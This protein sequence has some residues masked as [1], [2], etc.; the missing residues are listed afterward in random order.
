LRILLVG[1]YPPIEGGVSGAV[2][3]AAQDLATA[4]HHVDVV[5]NSNEVEFGFREFFWGADESL[6]Q[7]KTAAGSVSVLETRPLAPHS[8]VPWTNPHVSKVVGR[9]LAATRVHE[10]DAIV[11]VYLEPYGVAAALVSTV[12]EKP[13]ILRHA[14]SDIGRLSEH[15]DLQEIYR[16]ALSRARIVLTGVRT[17]PAYERLLELGASLNQVR[18]LG[19]CA[20]PA[21]FSESNEVL[22]VMELADAFNASSWPS[23]L[24]PRHLNEI[25]RTNT[26]RIRNDCPTIGT[27]GK[28]GVTKGSFAIIEAL[29]KLAAKGYPFN[30]VTLAGGTPEVLERYCAKILEYPSLRDRSWILPLIAPWRIP[31][32]LRASNIVAFLEHNFPIVA[33]RPGI[34]REVL[35]VG[36]CLVCSSEIAD[37]QGFHSNMVDG[38]NYVRINTPDDSDVLSSKLSEVISD[39]DRCHSI[40]RHGMF[41]SRV[42]EEGLPRMDPIVE[43]IERIV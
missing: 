14:G 12:I 37:K 20:L 17:G 5:T 22:N 23:Q 21:W 28:V 8:Y 24:F 9:A 7:L 29:Q 41:L 35:A 42:I 38:K 11:G 27:Y 3:R 6:L 36:T 26:K 25:V 16:W 32:F 15:P 18:S 2:F 33:H 43:L 31:A 40:G 39:Q 30:F 10:Y 13:L 34:P 19:A 1:K 4:G